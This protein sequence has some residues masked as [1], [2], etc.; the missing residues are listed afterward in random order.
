MDP[1]RLMDKL[2]ELIDEAGGVPLFPSQARLDRE[3]VYDLLDQIRVTLPEES[4]QA[5]WIVDERQEMLA[6]VKREAERIL[7][8][9]RE[10]RERLLSR[11]ELDRQAQLAAEELL[12]QARARE[13]QLVKGAEEYADHVM[14]ALEMELQRYLEAAVRGR[15]QIGEDGR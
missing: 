5:R 3:A 10:E 7:K 14:A 9:A 12:S 2:T 8:Q 6:E 13:G 1:L 11:E 15:N 4:K